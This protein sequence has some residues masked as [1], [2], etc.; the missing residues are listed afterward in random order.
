M[1][2]LL[3]IA[4]AG[5]YLLSW[6]IKTVSCSTQYGNSCPEE[7]MSSLN[8][9]KGSSIVFIGDKFIQTIK[10]QYRQVHSIKVEKHF[11]DSVKVTVFLSK[12]IAAITIFSDPFPEL[13]YLI[14]ADNYLVGQTSAPGN[15]PRLIIRADHWQFK[16]HQVSDKAV[17]KTLPYLTFLSRS[18]S[19]LMGFLTQ[20]N[21]LKVTLAGIE[22]L[23]SLDKDASISVATL[24]LALRDPTIQK[25][26]PKSID[27]RFESPVLFY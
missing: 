27:L 14:D 2:V 16:N 18:Y 4:V 15:I 24:Q 17:I 11:P 13:W 6:K 25:N 1:L 5:K 21:D 20:T 9:L 7:L 12:P 8:N 23:F 22:I 3:I 26:P 19:P 10:S